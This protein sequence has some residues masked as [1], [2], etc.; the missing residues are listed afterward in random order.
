MAKEVE[1]VKQ[2][3]LP[4]TLSLPHNELVVGMTG[5]GKTM[6]LVSHLESIAKENPSLKKIFVICPTIKYNRTFKKWKF[7]GSA[8]GRKL[9][10]FIGCHQNAVD[11]ELKEIL[12]KCHKGTDK[13]LSTLVVLDDCA[14]SKDVKGKTNHLVELAFTGRHIGIGVVVLTQQLTS[15]S[16]AYRDNITR[17]V[18][19]YSAS[20]KDTKCLFDEYLNVTKVEFD[21]LQQELK[22]KKWSKLV[23]NRKYP[24]DYKV[25]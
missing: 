25:L 14:H 22:S 4:L 19:F 1:Q 6:Y 9:I 12:K 23:V 5:S 18:T 17:L 15:V 8:V 3:K 24:Y 20:K 13:S 10:S 16:K 21:K 2:V 7:A 11:L